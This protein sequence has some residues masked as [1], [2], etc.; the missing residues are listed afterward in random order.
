VPYLQLSLPEWYYLQKV[1]WKRNTFPC[2]LPLF[3]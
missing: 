1:T 2:C 3:S